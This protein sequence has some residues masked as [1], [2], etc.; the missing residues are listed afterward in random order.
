MQTMKTDDGYGP[1]QSL[2]GGQ[3]WFERR[4]AGTIIAVCAVS[5]CV[6]AV[7][8]STR[9]VEY[10]AY[11]GFVQAEEEIVVA[12]AVLPQ[13]ASKM[14]LRMSGITERLSMPSLD[15]G[16]PMDPDDLDSRA[17]EWAQAHPE[18]MQKITGCFAVGFAIG[19]IGTFCLVWS[20]VMAVVTVRE[21]DRNAW[22]G[23]PKP[24]ELAERE[25]LWA[26]GFGALLRPWL[27]LGGVGLMFAGFMVAL[28]PMCSVLV[29]FG[30]P[31][32]PTESDCITTIVLL[33]L[34]NVISFAGLI[35]SFC[36]VCTRPSAA[37]ICSVVALGAS[38]SLIFKSP[39][40]ILIWIALSAVVCFFY[41]Q[42]IPESKEGY[43]PMPDF[44]LHPA[45][46]YQDGYG[47]QAYQPPYARGN[48]VATHYV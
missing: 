32:M 38:I 43:L 14:L 12:R 34:L 35:V 36:W 45:N 7:A 44:L 31:T 2:P 15:G 29:D 17:E 46:Q 3:T 5:V 33:A 4:G 9:E 1:Y 28:I 16:Q 20:E 22:S 19:I 40:V 27:S 39:W 11:T 21:L 30:L 10:D 24:V 18:E 42:F 47:R 37:L 25:A 41:F 23:E 13:S 48:P 8:V 6:L 26:H